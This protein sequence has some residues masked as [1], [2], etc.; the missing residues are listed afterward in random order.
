MSNG[1]KW[2]QRR[3][4]AAQLVADDHLT[5]ED[6]AAKVGISSKQLVRWKKQ[7]EFADKVAELVA[8]FDRATCRSSIAVRARRIDSYLADWDRIQTILRERGRTG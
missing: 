8:E 7:P 1:F 3:S 2:T 6:I 4:Q 5:D